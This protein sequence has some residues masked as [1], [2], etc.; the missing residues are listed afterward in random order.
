[1]FGWIA[2]KTE[3][4]GFRKLERD[5]PVKGELETEKL[6]KRRE[7][8]ERHSTLELRLDCRD[9]NESPLFT[10]CSYLSNIEERLVDS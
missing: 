9:R 4:G 8:W 2:Q 3:K 5:S 6:K 1:M 7:T 10:T